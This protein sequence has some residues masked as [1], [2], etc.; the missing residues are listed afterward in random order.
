[1]KSSL[2][3]FFCYNSTIQFVQPLIIPTCSNIL[4]YSFISDDCGR[5]DS[6]DRI[7]DV[8]GHDLRQASHD[9]AVE[10]IRQSGNVVVFTVQSLL[11]LS[12]NEESS[13][14]LEGESSTE[15]SEDEEEQ[16][17]TDTTE[18]VPIPPP[19]FANA[20]DDLSTGIPG[21]TASQLTDDEEDLPPVP[22]PPGHGDDEEENKPAVDLENTDENDDDED[23]DEDS[24][25]V[26][27]Q[28]TLANGSVIDKASAAFV[29]KADNDTEVEDEFGYTLKKI[30]KKYARRV[31]KQGGQVFCVCINKGSHGLGISLAGHKDR[32][33]MAVYICGLNP[34]GNASRD[35]RMQVRHFSNFKW[36][37]FDK[38]LCGKL[39]FLHV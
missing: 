21:N 7:L 18:P 29:T 19:E 14:N 36:L 28:M 5:L 16:I 31:V 37:C 39:F 13:T 12:R 38:T 9:K 26:A 2:L 10:V 1:M 11:G 25:D 6:G 30:Q 32:S 8:D 22:P 3:P 24:G 17:M 23:D 4:R 34:Q 20:M 27:G 35:G 33:Q 15:V